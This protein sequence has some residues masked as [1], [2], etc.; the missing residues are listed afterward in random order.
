MAAFS[1]MTAPA[2]DREFSLYHYVFVV[3][4]VFHFGFGGG[5]GS[6]CASS[7][8]LLVCLL[9]ICHLSICH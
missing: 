3:L 7:W 6:D 8:S 9:F 1:R 4:A 2:V 5:V